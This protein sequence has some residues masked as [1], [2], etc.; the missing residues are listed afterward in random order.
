MKAVLTMVMDVFG[1]DTGTNHVLS[2][3]ETL[4]RRLPDRAAD[5]R[6]LIV[7]EAQFLAGDVMRQLLTYADHR[8]APLP[9]VFAG[10][11]HTLKKTH[12]NFAAFDQIE[13]RI[14][15]R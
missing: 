10:N 4:R 3:V 13:T 2:M 1:L 15:F 9:I 14:G 11:E 8:E 6:Y 5:G 12:A 7:D